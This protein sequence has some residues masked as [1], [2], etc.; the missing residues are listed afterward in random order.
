MF[1]ITYISCNQPFVVKFVIIWQWE[2][3]GYVVLNAENISYFASIIIVRWNSVHFS[4][5]WQHG[6]RIIWVVT[7][8]KVREKSLDAFLPQIKSELMHKLRD[9]VWR[10]TRNVAFQLRLQVCN[11]IPDIW[12]FIREAHSHIS[13]TWPLR[14]SPGLPCVCCRI[15]VWMERTNI[16]GHLT[17]SE[18]FNVMGFKCD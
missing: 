1:N 7:W 5:N 9:V 13:V 2:H 15:V 4:R 17:H 18:L 8:C 11:L 3:Q 6:L 14:V 12:F 16:G 10:A